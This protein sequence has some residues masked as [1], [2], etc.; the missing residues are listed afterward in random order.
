MTTEIPYITPCELLAKKT[1]LRLINE[2]YI[3]VK[4]ESEAIRMLTN[5]NS[6]PEDWQLL[7][8]KSLEIE[9]REGFDDKNKETH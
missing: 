1:V 6:K 8:E 2:G 7:I 5:G 3:P 9:N 4:Y